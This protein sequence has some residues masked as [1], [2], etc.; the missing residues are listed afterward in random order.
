M[1]DRETIERMTA[2]EYNLYCKEEEE[3][4]QEAFLQD[5]LDHEILLTELN[6]RGISMEQYEAEEEAK[7]IE[8]ELAAEQ[9][10]AAFYEAEEAEMEADMQRRID[11]GET[12]PK[13]GEHKLTFGDFH[14]PSDWC[15][16]CA[17]EER[18]GKSIM[19]K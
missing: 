13:C 6:Y 16:Y 1:L 4:R 19:D 7:R 17:N 11:A 12:C 2:E 18:Y 10:L 15:E 5:K 3:Y 9:E 8:V 14:N